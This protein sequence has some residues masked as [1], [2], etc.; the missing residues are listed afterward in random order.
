[1]LLRTR[2]MGPLVIFLSAPG[3]LLLC[4]RPYSAVC[5]SSFALVSPSVAVVVSCSPSSLRLLSALWVSSRSTRPSAEALAALLLAPSPMPWAFAHEAE[6]RR[7]AVRHREVVDVRRCQSVPRRHHCRRRL[8]A[9]RRP[10][11]PSASA[12]SAATAA[13][14]ATATAAAAAAATATATATT[15]AAANDDA[16]CQCD[17]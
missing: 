6:V 17:S 15:T 16:V 13:A 2:R 10:A 4:P 14:T 12:P 3:P 9:S 1:M 11:P 7:P 8:H 5:S